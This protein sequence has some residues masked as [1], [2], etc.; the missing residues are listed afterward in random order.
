M[1]GN[2]GS[3]R[4]TDT[5]RA[6]TIALR[7]R[8]VVAAAGA[9]R[10]QV[11]QLDETFAAW[12][13]TAGRLLTLTQA[14]LARQADGY[15]AAFVGSEL[16]TAAAP[17]GVDVAAFAGVTVDGRPVR[18]LLAPALFTVKQALGAG[19][20]FEQASALGRARG[21][22]NVTYEAAS[23]ADRALD[24]AIA[25]E[26][27]VRGWRRVTSTRPCGACIAA[28]TG[29]VQKTSVVLERHPHCSCSKEPV[30]AGVRERV[31]RP[32]GRE[33]FDQLSKADQDALFAGRG[34]EAKAE[35]IRSGK[36]D[37][38]DLLSR[39]RQAL[40]GRPPILTE[41]PLARLSP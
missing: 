6:R 35:L 40:E 2:A 27:R 23:T 41:T 28:A 32:T 30:V 4:I 19:R 16:G 39:D 14:E 7:R 21:V 25:A 13:A 20:P 10:L 11:D 1:P 22:R 33:L 12:L 29:A 24:E 17:A 38:G 15:L 8:L 31:R 9:W 34:G 3:A 37:L 36:V 5:Y 18:E 26:P